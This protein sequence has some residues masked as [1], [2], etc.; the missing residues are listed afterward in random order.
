MLSVS[1]PQHEICAQL[2]IR[3]GVL[4]DYKKLTDE[5]KVDY[6]TVGRMSEDQIHSLL[7]FFPISNCQIRKQN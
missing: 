7:R 3:R 1:T 5:A 6:S 4:N 2:H